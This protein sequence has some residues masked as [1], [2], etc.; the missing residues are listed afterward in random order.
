ML[1]LRYLNFYRKTPVSNDTFCQV[2]SLM[3]RFTAL[4]P[5]S[6]KEPKWFKICAENYLLSGRLNEICDHN[7]AVA[8]NAGRND[9]SNKINL[10]FEF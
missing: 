1:Q 8:S 7:S 10:L 3:H 9:V 6:F 5:S 4:T 2:S